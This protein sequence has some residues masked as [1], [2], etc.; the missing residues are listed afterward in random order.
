M[1]VQTCEKIEV[2]ITLGNNRQSAA[3]SLIMLPEEI[4]NN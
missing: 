1:Y 4:E 3:S 2:T